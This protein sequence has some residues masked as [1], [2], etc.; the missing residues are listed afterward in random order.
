MKSL[1]LALSLT[2]A[3]LSMKGLAHPLLNYPAPVSWQNTTIVLSLSFFFFKFF[4]PP[5]L[6]H[7]WHITKYQ[8]KVY[9]IMIWYTNRLQNDHN[10]MFFLQHSLA[11]PPSLWPLGHDEK[12]AFHLVLILHTHCVGLPPVISGWSL[13][14]LMSLNHQSIS[15]HRSFSLYSFVHQLCPHL[16]WFLVSAVGFTT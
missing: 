12:L 4:G 13:I 1:L 15:H 9:N 3:P 11:F 16:I 2:E 7:N 8:F 5:L 10:K 14:C 6:S